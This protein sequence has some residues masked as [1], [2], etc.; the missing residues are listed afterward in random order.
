[1]AL[2]NCNEAETKLPAETDEVEQFKKQITLS[3]IFSYIGTYTSSAV[4][5]F[6][7]FIKRPVFA[8]GRWFKSF[9]MGFWQRAGRF[10]ERVANGFGS[11]FRSIHNLHQELKE[12]EGVGAKGQRTKQVLAHQV[13]SGRVTFGKFLNVVV[14]V[15]VIVAFGFV[16]HHFTSQEYAIAVTHDGEVVAYIEKESDFDEATDLIAQ[17]MVYVNDESEF[18]IQPEFSL[19]KI[20]EKEDLVNSAELA[21]KLISCSSTDISTA[22]GLYIDNQFYGATTNSANLETTLENILVEYQQQTGTTDASFVSPIV[23]KTGLYLQDAIVPEE[24]LLNLVNSDVQSEQTYTVVPGDTFTTIAQKTSVSIGEIKALNPEIPEETIQIGQQVKISKTIP[25]L[26]VTATKQ[27]EYDEEVP[28]QSITQ[29]DGNMYQG[30]TSIAQ[31]GQNGINH[32]TALVQVVN[33]EEVSKTV[34]NTAQVSAPVNEIKLQGTKEPVKTSDNNKVLPAST[35]SGSLSG[36]NFVRP[37]SSGVGKVSRGVGNGHHGIDWAAPSGTPIY[38]AASGTVI[39]AKWYSGYGLCV[40][41]DHG[42]GVQTLYGHQS[43]LGVSAGQT[44]SAGQQIGYVGTTGQSTGNH[45]HFEIRSN[46]TKL[47]PFDYVPR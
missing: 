37:L 16:V 35:G 3:S 47:D 26:S 22:T 25:F 12:I 34:T 41:I 42:N 15:V 24:D 20:R 39:L 28:Y 14:P 43:R 31:A 21:N 44:V 1:M 7:R 11:P 40:I 5:H 13:H 46:G 18:D 6:G 8:C 29:D 9:F 2:H 30:Q 4:V 38:A 33:G 32:V 27:V 17:Q 19:T 10:A 23:L 36:V 45:L